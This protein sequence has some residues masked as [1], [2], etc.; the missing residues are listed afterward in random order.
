MSVQTLCEKFIREKRNFNANGHQKKYMFSVTCPF[1]DVEGLRFTSITN[2]PYDYLNYKPTLDHVFL[3]EPTLAAFERYV[4]L[5]FSVA[6]EKIDMCYFKILKTLVPEHFATLNERIKKGRYM[7]SNPTLNYRLPICIIPVLELHGIEEFSKVYSVKSTC[8]SLERTQIR[9]K[10]NT[11]FRAV[12][13]L[14]DC[15][16]ND[17]VE[18]LVKKGVLPSKNFQLVSTQK[19][20]TIGL[21]IV[22][23][24]GEIYEALQTGIEMREMNANVY[25]LQPKYGYPNT[26]L[27]QALE[28]LFVMHPL[29]IKHWKSLQI[30]TELID[31]GKGRL[32]NAIPNRKRKFAEHSKDQ[33]SLP[34]KMLCKT[35]EQTWNDLPCSDKKACSEQNE[36]ISMPVDLAVV[37]EEIVET[38][39]PEQEV[40]ENPMPVSDMLPEEDPC[41]V[42]FINQCQNE[43]HEDMLSQAVRTCIPNIHIPPNFVAF[44]VSKEL[45]TNG[46]VLYIPADFVL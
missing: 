20:L 22:R 9:L 30:E 42:Y 38:F 3:D 40:Q 36:I 33:S 4:D 7:Q 23:S 5:M 15:S 21:K 10:L 19:E 16:E 37:K 2:S 24:C 39:T 17:I 18:I 28:V 26:N 44:C 1:T 12:M 45:L 31:G 8:L 43:E 32:T 14:L 34:K 11:Y 29:Y 25:S 27:C 46:L 41:K 35:Q 6:D 13:T